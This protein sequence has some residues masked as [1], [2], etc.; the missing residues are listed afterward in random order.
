[1]FYCMVAR[2]VEKGPLN[3]QKARKQTAKKI[4]LSCFLGRNRRIFS[5]LTTFRK[6]LHQFSSVKTDSQIKLVAKKAKH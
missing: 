1:M 5:A 6:T 2:S 4:P 3:A